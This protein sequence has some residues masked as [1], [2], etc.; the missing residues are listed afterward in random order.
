MLPTR[1][2]QEMTTRDFADSDTADWITVLPV[3]AIEQHGPHLPVA[4]DTT[5]PECTV[6][7]AA[8]SSAG[9]R[10]APVVSMSP[11][12]IGSLARSPEP[13]SSWI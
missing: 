4:T 2:W 1:R 12:V 11:P 9:R 8:N 13:L 7:P 10:A 3:A 5:D 6:T